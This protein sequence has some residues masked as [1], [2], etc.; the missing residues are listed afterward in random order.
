MP[1]ACWGLA[2]LIL[3]ICDP[4]SRPKQPVVFSAGGK[5]S[6]GS[7]PEASCPE[8]VTWVLCGADQWSLS[9]PVEKEKEQDGFRWC[10]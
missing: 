6:L 7:K 2:L 10:S 9:R 5:G 1:A 8:C 3:L 4:L